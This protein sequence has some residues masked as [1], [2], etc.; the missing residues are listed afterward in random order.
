MRFRALAV[1]LDKLEHTSSRNDITEILSQLFKK[2]NRREIGYIVNLLL[3]RLAPAHESLVF[4]LADRMMLQTI[5]ASFERKLEDVKEKYKVRGDI[6]MVAEEFY[7]GSDKKHSVAQVFKTLVG[8]AE[9]E[10]EGSVERKVEGMAEL[11]GEVDSLSARYLARI[12]VGKLRL[13]F[14]DKTIIDALSYYL[15]GDKTA[16]KDLEA[17]YQV[18]PDVGRLAERVRASGKVPTAVA[19]IVGVP[20]MPMLPQRLKSTTEM[21]E[22]MGEV[23]V[24]PKF[25]GLRVIIHYKKGKF[26]KAYTRNLNEIAE[27]FPELKEIGKQIRARSA[28]IDTEAVGLNPRTQKMVDFQKTM[29]RRRKHNIGKISEDIPVQFQVFDLMSRNGKNFMDKTYVERREAL[30]KTIKKGAVLVEDEYL[31]TDDPKLIARDHARLLKLGLEGVIVKRIDST[32]VPGRT[33]WRWVKMK[34]AEGELG[35]LSDTVDALVMGYTRGQGKR[36]SFGLGQ[37]LA[38]VRKG[39][40]YLSITKVGT[41]LTDAQFK[42]LSKMLKKIQVKEKPASYEVIKDLEPDFW[43]RPSL[44]VELAADEITKSPRHTSHYALRF[45][46]LVR[47]RD[48]KS[49]E[50]VTSVK[51]IKQLYKLQKT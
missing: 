25:D 37:F 21:I 12:P 8:I 13:G 30:S 20:V 33:G 39:E 35:K 10:G 41:G 19:P 46:R 7:K 42:K 27:M 36:A 29:T 48:D 32:Y 26:T 47:F 28:I 49:P 3:G 16:K 31:V 6:G 43:V 34:E 1:Y 51:E 44:V 15:H 22:K 50:Q 45:P 24:E 14:S 38:A 18:M 11:L 23:A 9:Y 5:A 4:N 2:S 17:S 40:K